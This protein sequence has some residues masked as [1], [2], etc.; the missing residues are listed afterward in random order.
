MSQLKMSDQFMMPQIDEKLTIENTGKDELITKFEKV[1]GMN[2]KTC[3]LI[4]GACLIALAVLW[5]IF[6]IDNN[7]K[8]MVD[9]CMNCRF[10]VGKCS[11]T[12]TR[13][14]FMIGATVSMLFFIFQ[15]LS[16]FLLLNS[17]FSLAYR[18]YNNICQHNNPLCELWLQSSIYF[19]LPVF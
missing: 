13:F 19:S 16:I 3:I 1:I 15:I 10:A 12:F 8:N 6:I 11:G 5:I 7:R 14:P 9:F 17:R 2:Q 4:V 18:P